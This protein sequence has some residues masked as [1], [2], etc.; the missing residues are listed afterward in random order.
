MMY[1]NIIENKSKQQRQ[2]SCTPE[3]K[4]GNCTCKA[5]QNRIISDTIKLISRNTTWT[6]RLV[7]HRQTDYWTKT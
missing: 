3:T 7:A 4:Q 6:Y 5:L 1:P 2:T